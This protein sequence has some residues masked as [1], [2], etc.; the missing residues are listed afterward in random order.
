[1]FS[2]RKKRKMKKI[3]QR[4][5]RKSYGYVIGM[6]ISDCLC[7]NF[8]KDIY[9]DV[10]I[11]DQTCIGGDLYFLVS[12]KSSE[13]KKFFILKVVGISK[14]SF[15]S[16]KNLIKHKRHFQNPV[17]WQEKSDIFISNEGFLSVE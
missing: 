1:M 8:P 13:V 16:T 17:H 7:V 4:R 10:V 11:V 14:Y 2:E 12:F 9:G 5:I 15:V 6:K 3:R